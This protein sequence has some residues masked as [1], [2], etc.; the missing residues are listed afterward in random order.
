MIPNSTIPDPKSQ[1]QSLCII[2]LMVLGVFI[3]VL[4]CNHMAMAGPYTDSAHGNSSYGVDRNA[5]GF[6]DYAVGNCAHCH[7]QHASIGGAE[8]APDSPAGPD[9]FL[10][11][12]DNYTDQ[13]TGFCFDC[14]KGTG[15]YQTSFSR[16]NYCYSYWAGG[17]TTI[18]CPGSILEAF[19]FINESGSPVSN[20]GSSYGS[21]HHL[22]DI[23]SFISGKWGYTAD[24]NP[25]IACHNPHRAKRDPHTS[26]S[27]GWPVS[28]PSGHSD[29][30]TWELWGDDTGEKMSDYTGNYQAPYRYNSSTT[31]EPDGSNIQT[32][33][34]LTDYAT[35]CTDCHNTTYTTITSTPLGRYLKTIDWN[36]EKHG[37][38]NADGD[39]DMENPYSSTLG[40]VLSCL[41]CH[42]PHGA[43]NVTLIREEVNGGELSTITT[44]AA[45]GCIT[46][47][48]GNKELGYLCRRCHEDDAD[49]GVGSTNRWCYAHH[50]SSDAPYNLGMCKD[51]HGGMSFT[52]ETYVLM[53]DRTYK[54]IGEIK[55]GDKVL[56]FDFD[57]K[58]TC[59]S[60]VAEVSNHLVSE[61]LEINGLR[62]TSGQRFSVAR[63]QWVEA[64][65][66]KTGDTVL[67]LVGHR[68]GLKKIKL[69]EPVSSTHPEEMEVVDILVKGTGNFFVIGKGNKF[70]VHNPPTCSGS[71]RDPINCNCC[72]YHGSSRSDCDYSPTTRRTF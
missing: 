44:I 32:G 14:H 36:N 5:T 2:I 45:S 9:N 11:F 46:S 12:S 43:P 29:V 13:T 71:S 58:R 16:T 60:E 6:P 30:Y 25:C 21:S 48:N 1:I 17:D 55:A 35:F 56:S 37:K 20:C 19:S 22:T 49:A 4:N 24:S 47:T 23:R 33:S 59:E 68:G 54:P 18:T 52:P 65:K 40:K 57:N 34:N 28:R 7:E 15:S 53:P 67:G 62:V 41:D 63:D 50:E 69:E 3:W 31:Y 64:G 27:R 51:C 61:T 42:E 26:G 38:G 70:L 39:I 8:P 72:H 10:L 66:L